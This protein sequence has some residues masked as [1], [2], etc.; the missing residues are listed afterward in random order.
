MIF[1]MKYIVHGSKN[2]KLQ[3]LKW[4]ATFQPASTGLLITH[5]PV[6]GRNVASRF[7]LRTKVSSIYYHQ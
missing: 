1:F 7:K 6:A 5:G 2:K 4:N 3:S